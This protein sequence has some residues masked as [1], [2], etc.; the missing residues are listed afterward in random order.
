MKINETVE[1][2][3]RVDGV[4]VVIQ[5]KKVKRNLG[6]NK[7]ETAYTIT[8]YVRENGNLIPRARAATQALAIERFRLRMDD[9]SDGVIDPP[10]RY[11]L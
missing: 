1:R 3:E 7:T 9:E 2:F 8:I 10:S 11:G 6:W 4:P 5:T